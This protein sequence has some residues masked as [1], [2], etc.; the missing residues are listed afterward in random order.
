TFHPV[1]TE[2]G[3][4]KGQAAELVNAL[5]EFP[6]IKFL[7]TK[8]NA[9]AE[10]RIIN[11]ELEDYA[12]ASSNLRLFPSLGM[13]RYLSALKYASFVIG[14]SSSGLV[15]APSFGIPTINIGDRQKGRLKATSVIDCPPEKQ[16]IM[17]AIQKALEQNKNITVINPYGDG[18]TSD[19]IVK[20]IMDK[21][22]SGE[23]FVRK[24][25]VDR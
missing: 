6:Q 7:A 13:K 5:K 2:G 20:I 19:K 16:E 25:F 9:D 11:K 1:T 17:K 4:A 8:A 22:V 14:N 24:S 12:A 18:N 3:S 21:F 23:L 15:E 10:G